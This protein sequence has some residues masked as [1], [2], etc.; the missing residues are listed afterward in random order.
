MPC[1]LGG[2]SYLLWLE[3]SLS[4]YEF[5]KGDPQFLHFSPTRSQV[6]TVALP[7]SSPSSSAP[8]HSTHTPPDRGRIP[9]SCLPSPCPKA[10]RTYSPRAGLGWA[11]LGKGTPCVHCCPLLTH[12]P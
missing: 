1:S 7:L 9:A 5:L 2:G 8:H 10:G 3:A 12:P 6:I 4:S 11:G